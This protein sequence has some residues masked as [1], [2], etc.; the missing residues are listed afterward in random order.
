MILTIQRGRKKEKS[1]KVGGEKS[2]E[3]PGLWVASVGK[4]REE[5]EG[6]AA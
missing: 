3:N 1:S 5:R 4:K 2:G 6:K